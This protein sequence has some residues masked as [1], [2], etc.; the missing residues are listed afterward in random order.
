MEKL[1]NLKLQNLERGLAAAVFVLMVIFLQ[2]LPREMGATDILTPS[3]FL[4]AATSLILPLIF[5]ALLS[6]VTVVYGMVSVGRMPIGIALA[7]ASVAG[8]ALLGPSL[9]VVAFSLITAYTMLYYSNSSRRE[10]KER[11]KVSVNRCTL[12]GLS[13]MTFTFVVGICLAFFLWYNPIVMEQGFQIPEPLVAL[14]S[15]FAISTFTG[16]GC[17]P[18]MKLGDCIDLIVDREEARLRAN[19][20]EKC[21]GDNACYQAVDRQITE[22]RPEFER[23]T[24]ENMASQLG[25]EVD[26][27]K[28]VRET[29]VDVIETRAD[30]FFGPNKHFIAPAIAMTLFAI[31]NGASVIIFPI[32]LFFSMLIFKLL[33]S[34]ELIKVE[35]RNEQVEEIVIP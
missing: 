21:A 11:K 12:W 26:E 4:G 17:T 15:N 20:R 25:I 31:L 6:A 8:I 29:V 3:G 16:Q 22:E 10:S 7:L 9:H 33:V 14:S 13:N 18:D 2:T 24:I 32:V 35:L 27:S 19:A 1:K 34:M 23:K 5:F 28:T 30:D